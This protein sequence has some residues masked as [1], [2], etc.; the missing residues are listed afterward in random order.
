MVVKFDMFGAACSKTAHMGLDADWEQIGGG[1]QKVRKVSSPSNEGGWE[2]IVNGPE[3][4]CEF[5]A[6]W[7]SGEESSEK[8]E[9]EIENGS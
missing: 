6:V 5:I 7:S 9:A 8:G 1:S 3:R 2:A 4:E